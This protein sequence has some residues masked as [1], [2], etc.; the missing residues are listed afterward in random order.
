M[1]LNLLIQIWTKLILFTVI[2]LLFFSISARAFTLKQL[3]ENQIDPILRYRTIETTHFEIHY[4]DDLSELAESVATQ[5]EDIHGR[6]THT[7][8]SSFAEKTNIVIVHKSDETSIYTF[9]F[10]HRQIFLDAALPH[11]GLGLSDFSGWHN[12]VLTHEFTHV[13]HLENRDGL[14][15]LLA[16]IFGSW[17]R[18]NQLQP[19]WVKEGLAVMF[20]T[21][22][23]PRGRGDSSTYK[24][25][26]R[27]A[28]YE[29]LLNDP[30]FVASDS[31]ANFDN[32]FWPWT[33]RPYLFGYHLMK[34]LQDESGHPIGDFVRA[35]SSSFP[36]RLEPGLQ[37]MGINSFQ[38]LWDKMLKSLNEKAQTELQK[39]MQ[40][41][42]TP[43]EYMTNSGFYHF[44]PEI[45]P[46]GKTLIVT[47][48][49]PTEANEILEFSLN[50]N[51]WSLPRTL[52][53]RSTGYQS[54]FSKS[55][56][57]VP[58]TIEPK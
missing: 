1:I 35:N 44:D 4:S 49:R 9:V 56:R 57:F 58:V 2:L 48:D 52:T 5:I 20:E 54:A 26:T 6:V 24:M 28:A 21:Q 13:V 27:M 17:M 11:Y 34:T 50:G 23:T 43:L 40:E 16:P 42:L 12:W 55:G 46:D 36:T 10:P 7:M 19:A 3:L 22:L 51:V 18:P 15:D 31:I 39:L 25:M 47:Y 45:S 14:Y 53:N 33:L 29:G 41:A 30:T 37:S 8:G 32:K 38:E